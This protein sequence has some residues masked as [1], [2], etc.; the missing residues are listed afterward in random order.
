MPALAKFI[1]LDQTK[2]LTNVLH[3]VVFL[4]TE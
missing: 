2:I 3:S 1:Q 4:L